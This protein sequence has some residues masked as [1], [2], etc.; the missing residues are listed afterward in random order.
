[1]VSTRVTVPPDPL[2]F[3]AKVDLAPIVAIVVASCS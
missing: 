2:E 1:V 3:A